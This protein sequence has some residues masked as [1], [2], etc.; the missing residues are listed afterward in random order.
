MHFTLAPFPVTS[1]P[2]KP[3]PTLEQLHCCL[4]QHPGVS[5]ALHKTGNQWGMQK[6]GKSQPPKLIGKGLQ[7]HRKACRMQ[8]FLPDFPS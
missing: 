3:N 4:H 2:K 6:G 1:A 5:T 8:P 7:D